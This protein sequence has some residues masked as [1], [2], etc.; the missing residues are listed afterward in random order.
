MN[1]TVNQE[2][3]STAAAQQDNRTFTQDEVNAIVA[4]RLAR[5]RAKYADYD[6]LKGK[7]AKF[8]AA[9]KA[10]KDELKAANDRAEG[11]Q[12]Q[13]DDLIHANDVRSIRAKAEAAT[14]VPADLLT[15]ETEEECTKQANRI[16]SFAGAGRNLYPHVLDGG[17]SD[18]R[19]GDIWI[20]PRPV[21]DA[22]SRDNKHTPKDSRYYY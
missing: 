11:L 15:F 13:L 19:N 10:S 2:T 14:G 9:D 17:E 21:S 20:G 1:E 16:L 12:K 6:D 5:E 4:D 3:N 18:A 8:D 7:A 22:F